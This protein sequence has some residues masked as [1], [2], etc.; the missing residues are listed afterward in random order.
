MG[1]A[2]VHWRKRIQM[3]DGFI[4]AAEQAIESG[5]EQVSLFLLNQTVEQCCKGLIYVFMGY[6]PSQYNIEN[7]LKLTA[8][9]SKLP[10]QH[11]TGTPGNEML[12]TVLTK[13]VEMIGNPSDF[14]LGNQSIYRFLELVESFIVL[15]KQM[16]EMNFKE[17]QQEL[18]KALNNDNKLN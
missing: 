13:C 16:C 4:K 1:R 10:L 6:Q 5:H 14:S 11:F 8:C 18:D 12:L 3:A 15:A 7:L 9:F 2:I 17:K